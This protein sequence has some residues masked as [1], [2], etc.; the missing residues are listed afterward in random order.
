MKSILIVTAHPDDEV[1]GCGGMIAKHSRNNEI[2][3]LVLGT[4]ITSRGISEEQKEEH[5]AKINEDAKEANELLGI[6]ELFLMNLPDN[7]FDSI[8]LLDITK[9]IESK[10]KDVKPDVI[11]THHSGDLNV[12]HRLTFE[13][14]L[15]ATRPLEHCPV[16]EIY[17]FEVPS[18]TEWRFS[19][20]ED[21]FTPNI[22]EDIT[23]TIDIKLKAMEIYESEIRKYPHPRSP[24]AL[25]IISQRW[26]IV[27]GLKY[28]E[29]FMLI[30]MI[31]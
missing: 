15:I 8:P 23:G 14:V 5:L 3:T 12:D 18:S 24:E 27:C 11:F 17:S 21:G 22:F 4:G 13:A 26:G 28:A 9:T 20:I 10:I 29:A 16:K 2:Y 6:K 30:R 25:K 1:L 31:R 7:K 19:K